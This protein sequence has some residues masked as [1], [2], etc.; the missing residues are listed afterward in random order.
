M[1]SDDG[2]V[3]DCAD[4]AAIK[5]EALVMPA[6]KGRI[7]SPELSGWVAVDVLVIK[8]SPFAYVLKIS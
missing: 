8:S 5:L 2:V 3:F 1:L 6:M 4:A 7:S